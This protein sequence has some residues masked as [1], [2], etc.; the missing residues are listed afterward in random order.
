MDQIIGLLKKQEGIQEV[1]INATT[2]SVLIRYDQEVHTQSDLEAI[3]YDFGEILYSVAAEGEVPDLGHSSTAAQLT[4]AISD[5]DRHI[6]N[7]TGG[8]ANLKLLIPLLMGA[9][10]VRQILRK[11]W[12]LADIPGYVLIWYAFD[13]FYKFHQ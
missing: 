10:G 1:D 11:G 13:A 12:G 6:F 3:L 9:I 2:G 4:Q 7:L 8:S 5:L